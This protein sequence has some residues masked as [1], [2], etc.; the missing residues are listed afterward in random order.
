[1]PDNLVRER[2]SYDID[3]KSLGFSGTMSLIRHAFSTRHILLSVYQLQLLP[4]T[5]GQL[6]CREEVHGYP[7][8]TNLI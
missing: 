6:G 2:L 1:M 4:K 8:L 5:I 3:S 7:D